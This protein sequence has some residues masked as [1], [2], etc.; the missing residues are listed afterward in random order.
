M[1]CQG[2]PECFV[3]GCSCDDPRDERDE[4]DDADED[5]RDDNNQETT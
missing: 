1:S 3:L 4:P 5:E 2:F